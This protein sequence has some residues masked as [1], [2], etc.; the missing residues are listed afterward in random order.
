MSLEQLANIAEVFGMIVVAIT[1]IFLTL[2]MRQNTKAQRST[3]TQNANEMAVAIYNPIVMDN[4]VADIIIRGL[5]DPGELTEVE[6]GRFTA[7]WQNV[8]FTW[9]NWYYQRTEGGLD[10]GIWAGFSKLL[11]DVLQ[12]P[13]LQAYW[14][15]RRHYFSDEFQSFLDKELHSR[16]QSPGY[17]VLGVSTVADSDLPREKNDA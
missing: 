2:Q 11:G 8:F 1:L 9:Q 17:K 16:E 3:T 15:Q 13:G 7:H 10:D 4:D 14:Q 5:R 6:M 12:T